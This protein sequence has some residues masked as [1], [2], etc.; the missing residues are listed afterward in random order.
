MNIYGDRGNVIVLSRRAKWRAIDISVQAVG[1]GDSLSVGAFDLIF[2]GG[3]QDRQQTLMATDLHRKAGVLRRMMADHC[4]VLAVCGGYQLLG[5]VYRDNEGHQLEGI[6]IFDAVTEHPGDRALR[7]IG[8]TVVACDWFGMG[9]TL[10]GFENHGGR[11][12]LGHAQPLGRVLSGFGNN[13]CDGLEGA[14]AGSAYGTYLHGPLLPK[15]PWFADHLLHLALRY[16]YG[17]DIPLQP[18]DDVLEERAHT[19]IAGRILR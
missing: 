18:L 5:H 14:I 1:V 8:N 11:T 6:G 2:I 17:K 16:R 19:T 15:N 7:C 4:P 10:V 9:A 3:G 13:G 12:Y